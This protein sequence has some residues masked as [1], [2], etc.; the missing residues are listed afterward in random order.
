VERWLPT[1]ELETATSEIV[2][3]TNV[4]ENVSLKH[5]T[6]NTN[7]SLFKGRN[8]KKTRGRGVYFRLIMR[9]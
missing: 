7:S 3:I 8:R 9:C 6:I 1:E 5:G 4:A 2:A